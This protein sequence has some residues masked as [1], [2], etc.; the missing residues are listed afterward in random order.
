MRRSGRGPSST[1][2]RF[3]LGY[4]N[5]AMPLIANQMTQ[6]GDLD[7]PVID[8]TG[9][10]GNVDFLIEFSPELPAGMTPPPN[11]DTT[12][13]RFLDALL[14][15]DGLKLISQKAP[16]DLIRVDHVEYPSP[17]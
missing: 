10:K 2:G 5:V 14:E 4:R 6:F 16:V 3:A 11:F 13:L 9:I 12:G 17:N 1:P 8:E 7:R 15:Q